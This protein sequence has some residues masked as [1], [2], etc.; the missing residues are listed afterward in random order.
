MAIAKEQKVNGARNFYRPLK[1]T[2]TL[3]PGDKEMLKGGA[4]RDV[5]P[6]WIG[7]KIQ[8]IPLKK[9]FRVVQRKAS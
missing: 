7:Q 6:V 8:D 5:P 1:A 2:D 4:L 9:A 3:E